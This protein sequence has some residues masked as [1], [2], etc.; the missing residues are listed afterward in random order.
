MEEGDTV[1]L[2]LGYGSLCQ[3]QLTRGRVDQTR[4]G[5]LKHDRL[6]GGAYG[7]R[8]ECAQGWLYPL[9]PTAELWT[10]ALPHRTQILYTPDI[11]MIVFQLYLKPG[12]VVVEAGTGSGSLSHALIRSVMPK[13]RVYTF[14]FHT[15]R[16]SEA[17]K[18]F[19]LHG[20]SD[21]V[22]TKH[23]DVCTQGFDLTKEAD[24]VFLDLPAPW[25]CIT[26]AKQALRLGGRI[27]TFSPCIEQVQ[28]TCE[29]LRNHRFSD[30]TTVECLAR[31]FS[32]NCVKLQPVDFGD[33]TVTSLNKETS[34]TGSSPSAG[35]AEGTPSA[36]EPVKVELDSAKT[37][38]NTS[39]DSEISVAANLFQ[40]NS[41][42]DRSGSNKTNG[43]D[44]KMGL[45]PLTMQGHTGF[46]T[47]AS[48]Y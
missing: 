31:P 17:Q 45:P 20:L 32:I 15:E 29:A 8:V 5:A 4:Y 12:S 47:F 44:Y 43:F 2:F 10:L 41:N 25:E 27:C 23:R 22:V 13:G 24:A 39:I 9:Q 3:L 30:L 7:V 26:S 46:L 11:S 35:A 14:E 28:R 48:L 19:E 40:T 21:F 36:K 34:I 42:R 1:L 37:G 18:E 6:I 16:C 33:T 38:N